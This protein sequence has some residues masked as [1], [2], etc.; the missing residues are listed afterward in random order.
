M[1]AL[2]CHELTEA[3]LLLIWHQQLSLPFQQQL[4]EAR[5]APGPV[6]CFRKAEASWHDR[7]WFID[8]NMMENFPVHE[9]AVNVKPS[10]IHPF[11]FLQL[12]PSFSLLSYFFLS[13]NREFAGLRR[14]TLTAASPLFFNR[15]K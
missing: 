4:C 1:F 9:E 6:T 10:H 14:V 5:S 11:P 8:C 2:N 12:F 15:R 13:Q 3:A 7:V